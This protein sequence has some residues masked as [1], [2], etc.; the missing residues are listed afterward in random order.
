MRRT[1]THARALV[2]GLTT[3]ALAGAAA[4]CGG[5]DSGGSSGSS[6]GKGGKIALLL[7]ESKTARYESQD[8]PRFIKRVKQLCPT[9][10]VI[11]ANAD[12]D[13]AKQQSQADSAL[14]QGAKVMVVDAVDVDAAGSIAQKA[15]TQ[16]VPVVSYGR[17]IA[18]APLD[19]YVSID[20]Y[21]VGQQQAKA[22]LAAQK[23]RGTAKPR[24]VMINGSPTDSNAGPYKKGAE[25]V[26][27]AAGAPIVKSYDTPDWS[28][29]KAR[30]EMQGAESALGKDGFDAVYA[31][32][33]GMAG[34]VIS[35][36]KSQGVD[37]GPKTITGQD[38]EVT[39]LQQIVA[40]N[41][42]M[43]VYQPIP[44]LAAVSAEIAV[45]LAQGKK[46]PADLTPKEV[47]NGGGK[48]KSAL[49]PTIAIDEKNMDSVIF[50]DGFATAKQV[51]SKNYAK[52]CKQ[53]GL[54][55]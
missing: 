46:P 23:K 7:P 3:V 1:Y 52:A 8:K 44:K 43:T 50:K 39:G 40:G 11:Y 27:K 29:D 22:L 28:P 21:Q 35:A 41:Q 47:D 32:N 6:G 38:A 16:G 18:K 54:L 2:A 26:F 17:L 24:I 36:L 10:E 4:G 42:L 45:P 12:Q 19:Y 15:K 48:V 25:D 14:A 55:K 49:L 34:G 20:P 5:S 13:A 51:C 33:D 37:P 9:C 30:S 53:A 31:A